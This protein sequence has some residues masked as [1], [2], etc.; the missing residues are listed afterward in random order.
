MTI[1]ESA[2]RQKTI[3]WMMIVLLLIGGYIAFQGLGRLEDPNFTIKQAVI[4]TQYPG[5]SA[6]VV[7]EEVTLP[8][9]N[10]IQQLPYLD[11]VTSTTM[12]GLSQ[13]M[14]EM[15]SIY[16]KDDLAQ[17]WDEMR[18][19]IRDMQ[20]H[21][22]PGVKPPIIN[23]DFGDVYGYF[24][25]ITGDGYQY[26]DL[27]DYVDYLR[28]ELV[29]VD[30]VGKVVVG[31]TR[32]R[33]LIIEINR[34]QMNA[35][36]LSAT[37]LQ[38]L[39]STQSLVTNAG[40]MRVG[41]EY[42]RIEP[43]GTVSSIDDV[44]NLVVGRNGNQLVYLT[45][46][47][48]L[49]LDYKDP[50]NHIYH[51]NGKN[52]LT[53]GI[54]FATGVNVVTVGKAVR[55]RM[56]EL[57]YM[58]PIGIEVSEIYNQ[59]QQVESSVENFIVGLA[60]SVGIVI[61]VLLIA[62]GL[63]PGILMSFVLLLTIAG[64]FIIMNIAG[65]ELHRISLGAL[66]IALGML[67]D[68]AIVITEGVMIGLHHGLSRIEAANRIVKNTSWPLLGATVIAITAFAPIG[69]SPDASGEF[70]G[71]LFWVLLI[72]LFLSW[73]LAITITPFL[74]YLMFKE[75]IGIKVGEEEPDPYKGIFY[76]I[77]R[78]I[79][80]F[81]LR[82]RWLTVLLI[83]AMFVGSL[84]GFGQVRQ[85]FFPDS[86]LPMFTVDY[87]L[88]EG[89]D[90]RATEADAK[91]LENYIKSLDS[92]EYVT[93]TIG[94]GAERFILTYAVEFN[95]PSYAQFII[96]T[97]NFDDIEPLIKQL[98]THTQEKYP[99]AFVKFDRMAI[100]PATKAKIEARFI[101]P[102]PRVLRELGEKGLAILRA[103]PDA[104]NVRQDWRQRTKVIRPI[105]NDEEARRLGIS[106][107]DLDNAIAL[108]ASGLSIGLYREGSTVLP[109]VLRPPEQERGTMEQLKNIQVFSPAK[110]AYVSI[111][112]IIERIDVVWED[113]LIKRRDRKRTLSV[114]AD[115]DMERGSNPAALL[116]K[117][118][119]AFE[120]IPL[121]PGYDLQWGGEYE[122]QAKAN[123]AV[124]AYVPI[125]ALLMV[126]ITVFMFNSIRQTLV[127]WITVPL[128]IIGVSTG[129]LIMNTPFSFTALLAVLSL[130]GMLIKN[131][132]VLVEEIK[133]LN[134]EQEMPWIQAI[135]QAAVSRM[136]PV[137]M[138]MITTVLGM[139]PLL[140]DVF[141]RPMAVSI[142]FGLGFATVLTLIMVP[143]LFALFYRVKYR[144][145]ARIAKDAAKAEAKKAP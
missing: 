66:I 8:I 91:K 80:R 56:E 95:A 68:N 60:Q 119:P 116:A 69:L 48:E 98:K 47:A 115:P 52:A 133:L 135:E 145:P 44:R 78:G 101:G 138:A 49:K 122:A 107:A 84:V 9:E 71:S 75:E 25:A 113:P 26:N 137:T 65:I 132:I 63:R 104:I 121:E 4:V 142:M 89:T 62:M 19:K 29:L 136:R 140:P 125:G 23:D 143:V 45:D 57:E 11:K 3:S 55:K 85:A 36:G 108:N 97:K 50:A 73:I 114:L 77:Y 7:E 120:A 76:R 14:V 139:I 6:Q 30:G 127:V 99:Q 12:G 126:V 15:K 43:T 94:R 128:A 20:G 83:M 35:L 31:G 1:A 28:R 141:F 2:I 40:N 24:L 96:R 37:S 144:S 64:T 34:S 109:I 22:P 110:Q 46:I 102:D 103:E 93:T 10:A 51:H 59:P 42:I 90:I 38:A 92:V 129:L 18:R 111:E 112:Q 100:G 16:R 13:I 17:I 134:E 86:P 54:S 21:L 124:F 79:V 88:P 87:W 105:F 106:K 117:I 58:R 39:L 41:S 118:R 82:F 53:L 123:K 70:T 130:S 61:V 33:Q 72:S 32:S 67:V 5:A 81:C 27:E 131:G 74:C